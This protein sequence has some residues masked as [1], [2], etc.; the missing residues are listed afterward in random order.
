MPAAP[1][2]SATP[3]PDI[4]GEGALFAF[5]GL[6]GTTNAAS[7]FTAALGP[8]PFG[9][10][11]HTPRRRLFTCTPP[12]APAATVRLAIGDVLLID[13]SQGELA[14]VWTAWHTLAG[15]APAGTDLSLTFEDGGGGATRAAT[16]WRTLDGE[17][18]DAVVL[19]VDE[20]RFGLAYGADRAEAEARARRGLAA[21]VPAEVGRRL[22][23]LSR[24]PH[25]AGEGRDRLLSKCLS[26][27]K[28]NAL[29]AE[30]AIPVLWSTP[31]RVP[32]RHLWLWDSVFHSFG[33][34]HVDPAAAWSFL[35]AVLACQNDDGMVSH[36]MQVDGGLST[37]TQPPILAWGVW[38]NYRVANDR[39]PLARA[40]PRLEAYLEWNLAHR[41][42]NHNDLLEWEISGEPLCR[43]GESG[44][45]NSPRFDAAA[46]VDAVDFS[47]FQAQDM[48]C[49]ARI[50][51]ELGRPG[52]AATWR[53]R[54]QRMARQI[55]QLLWDE[56]AGLYTDRD[57]EGRLT[58][59]KAVSGFLPLLLGD[60]AA[61]RV[62]ALAAHVSNPDTFGAPFPLPSASLDEPTWSTDMW[63]GATWINMNWL[64][65]QGFRRCHRAD[66]ADELTAKTLEFVERYYREYGVLFEFFDARDQRP[67][68]ACDRKGPRREPYDI[69]RKVDSI[70][71]Y[72][73]TASLVA[74]LLLTESHR[75]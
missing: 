47:T 62:E 6:D 73:F 29:A 70:R 21:D 20:G 10:L 57:L 34:N 1:V 3:L 36:M 23:F 52:A 14:Q 61:D 28:V 59:V 12:D 39:E 7:Q 56:G 74:D 31:D 9:L 55:H 46:L 5:S 44:M 50:A 26:V 60:V 32:H 22:A 19:V 25:A 18:G 45:D 71:D 42:R 53:E 48:E 64:V 35:E 27:M 58:G 4:W 37:I 38:D 69:R 17:C 41:D 51:D 68:V 43:S 2:P 67:P 15:H 65:I 13:T 75:G 30:G 40:F 24:A 11:I 63:R 66:V 33:M 8:A 72:H 49:L 16:T 54:S